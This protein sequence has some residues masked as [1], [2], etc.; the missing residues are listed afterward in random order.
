[1]S[2]IKAEEKECLILNNDIEEMLR[3]ILRIVTLNNMTLKNLLDELDH[4]KNH[5]HEETE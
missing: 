4:L 5:V 3:L 1:M 2:K